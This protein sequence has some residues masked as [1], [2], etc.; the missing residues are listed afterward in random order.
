MPCCIVCL[1]LG[2][3]AVTDLFKPDGLYMWQLAQR[4][5]EHLRKKTR[6]YSTGSTTPINIKRHTPSYTNRSYHRLNHKPLN[7]YLSNLEHVD[8]D[9]VTDI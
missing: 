3:P 7:A 6:A 2:L 5:G 4:L 9:G 8:L 1:L